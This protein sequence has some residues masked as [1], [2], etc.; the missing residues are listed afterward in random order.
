MGALV[1]LF[2]QLIMMVVSLSISLVFTM[3]NLI[4]SLLGRTTRL[5]AGRSR[6]PRTG[7][8]GV[9]SLVLGG[10]VL[11]LLV[12]VVS[13]DAASYVLGLILLGAIVFGVVRVVR[14][15]ARRVSR[16]PTP[17]AQELYGLL[18][19]VAFMDGRQFEIFVARVF[20]TMGY[21]ARVLGGSGDQGVDI[22]LQTTDGKVAVQ[23]KNYKKA[24]GNKPVQ[25]VYAGA[26]HH[27][28]QHAWVVAPAGYTKGAHELARSVGVL[29]Y[30]AASLRQWINQIDRAEAEAARQ[31]EAQ[32]AQAPPSPTFALQRAQ[33]QSGPIGR[34]IPHPDDPPRVGAVK[35]QS[36]IDRENY[37]KLLDNYE[38]YVQ[39]LARLR[40]MKDAGEIP[41][42]EH[43]EAQWRE[44]WV[45]INRSINTTTGK[46][47]ILEGRNAE[48]AG[49]ARAARRVEIAERHQE[50]VY[51]S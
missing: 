5:S 12:S 30:D 15:L 26:R 48:I 49:E 17:Q 6:S 46:L 40:G 51:G 16:P 29:L 19:S 33:G 44:Q 35:T 7:S 4:F 39:L 32:A 41:D 37:D 3:F 45:G 23:C 22:I 9:G 50:A 14:W 20:R 38:Q 1:S 25:E 28:C 2:V 27:G 36:Q 42:V 21:D 18:N 43:V 10:I 24:V 8:P 34:R 31:R 47:D 11:A 13:S